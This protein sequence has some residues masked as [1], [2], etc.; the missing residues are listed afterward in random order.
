M[1]F[2]LI[3]II[4]FKFKQQVTGQTGN[5]GTKDVEIMVPLKYLKTI[6]R[7]LEI[8]LINYEISLELKW[9]KDCF[10]VASTS[11]NQLSEI[12]ITDAKPYITVVTLST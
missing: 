5:S 6:W 8:P 9:S 10:L 3:T 4:V 7:S 2:L 11:A 1:I 12:N